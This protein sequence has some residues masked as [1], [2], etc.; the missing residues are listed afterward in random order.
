V[1]FLYIVIEDS[2]KGVDASLKV[3][4]RWGKQCLFRE[5]FICM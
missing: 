2:E 4:E 5:G 1:V 3:V